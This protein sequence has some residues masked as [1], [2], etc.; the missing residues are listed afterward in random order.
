MF[1]IS[2]PNA[3]SAKRSEKNKKTVC[4]PTTPNLEFVKM[5][6][7]Q[8]PQEVPYCIE[9]QRMEHMERWESP[10]SLKVLQIMER[11]GMIILSYEPC[12]R[13]K[14]EGVA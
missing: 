11:I 6:T 8:K 7:N 12:D 3:T 14:E 1:Y 4:S 2:P 13:C 9:H 5:V 10:V